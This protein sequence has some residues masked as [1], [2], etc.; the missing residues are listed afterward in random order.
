MSIVDGLGFRERES[1][2]GIA[3]VQA[4]HGGLD[5][6]SFRPPKEKPYVLLADLD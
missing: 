5:L 4:R 6:P 2:G 1:I 3:G